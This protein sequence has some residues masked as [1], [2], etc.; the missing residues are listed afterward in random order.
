[1]EP[2]N[3]QPAASQDEQPRRPKY[4]KWVKIGFV[5]AAIVVG[6]LVYN[7]QRTDPE[8]ENAHKQLAPALAQ[9]K[10]RN[11]RVVVVYTRK[12]M[13]HDDQEVVSKYFTTKQMRD[14]LAESGYVLAH[15]DVYDPS[16]RTYGVKTT[17]AYALLDGDGKLLKLREGVINNPTFIAEFLRSSQPKP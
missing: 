15:L 5:L 4:D 10:E 6:Y 8:L 1:M 17:P 3:T 16:A 11:T 14:A 13:S 2:A 7:R 12:P 9:A